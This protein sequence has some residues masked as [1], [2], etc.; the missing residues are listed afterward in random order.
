[1]GP[2]GEEGKQV[3]VA[4]AYVQ[5]QPSKPTPNGGATSEEKP[6]KVAKECTSSST[7]REVAGEEEVVP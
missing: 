4:Q 5:Q 7:L 1:M 3:T 6:K 2:H